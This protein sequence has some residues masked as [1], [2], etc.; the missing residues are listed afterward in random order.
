[1]HRGRTLRVAVWAH[2]GNCVV[3]CIQC[4]PRL[5]MRTRVCEAQRVAASSEQVQ[6]ADERI[7][8][9]VEL[10]GWHVPSMPPDHFRSLTLPMVNSRPIIII[11]VFLVYQLVN[12]GAPQVA[13]SKNNSNVNQ[14]PVL[15]WLPQLSVW[16]KL[17]WQCHVAFLMCVWQAGIH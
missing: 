8:R 1:M 4:H 7:Y 14:L 3:Q 2:L 16:Y 15:S 11:L 12:P 5:A 17:S 13:H 10:Q 6:Y 9:I